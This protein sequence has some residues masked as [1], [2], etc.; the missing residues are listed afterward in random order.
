MIMLL[1]AAVLISTAIVAGPVSEAE[2][3]PRR[4]HAAYG[5]SGLYLT[6]PMRHG[7][8]TFGY[9]DNDR[10]WG[11]RPYNDYGHHRERRGNGWDKRGHRGYYRW[12]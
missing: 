6:V 10:G 7:R 1:A 5:R 8:M 4:R 3:R 9:Y 12:R 11:Y 2:A